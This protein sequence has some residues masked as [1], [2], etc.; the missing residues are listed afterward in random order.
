MSIEG[1]FLWLGQIGQN[2]KTCKK[3][4]NI[5][6]IREH[7]KTYETIPWTCEKNTISIR[8]HTISCHCLPGVLLL[9]CAVGRLLL[10]VSKSSN[11]FILH[12]SKPP[13]GSFFVFSVFFAFV[14]LCC[15]FGYLAC[16]FLYF[17]CVCLNV[18]CFCIVH[19]M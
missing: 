11:F 16:T 14:L 3:Y 4:E 2:T 12:E 13:A 7:T 1:C 6:K 15:I 18:N 10:Y 19:F 17:A 5:P 8:K 9:E